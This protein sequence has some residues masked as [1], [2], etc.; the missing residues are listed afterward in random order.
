MTLLVIAMTGE[1]L[2]GEERCE[3]V[4]GLIVPHSSVA[5]DELVEPQP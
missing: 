2:R 5:T 1:K 3:D 4:R